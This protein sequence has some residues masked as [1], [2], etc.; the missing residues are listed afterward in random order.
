MVLF[1]NEHSEINVNI[2]INAFDTQIYEIVTRTKVTNDN[3]HQ[4]LQ[5]IEEITPQGSTNI[6]FALQQ[7]KICLTKL[8]EMYP[9]NVVSHIFMTDGEATEGSKDIHVLQNLVDENVINAFIG[10]GIEHDSVLLNVIGAVGKSAYYFIDKL[11]SSGLV[12]GVIL[13]SIIYKLV[14][15]VEITIENGFVYNFKTNEWTNTLYTGDIISEANKT[16][17]IISNDP[18]NC[19]MNIKGT[20]AN[21]RILFPSKNAGYVD[22]LTTHIYRQR[23]LQLLYQVNQ[24]SDMPTYYN[25]TPYHHRHHVNRAQN[26]NRE[27]DENTKMKTKLTDFLEELKKYMSDNNLEDDPVLK[28]LCD[29]V[30]ICFRTFGT[31]FAHMYC[32]ARQYS[33]GSQRQYTASSVVTT[34][35]YSNDDDGMLNHVLNDFNGTP[36][37]TPQ[38]TQIM[39]GICRP[40]N[41]EVVTVVHMYS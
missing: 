29:D 2:T 6:E 8:K 41:D 13:H 27:V 15:N 34:N 22:D 12:Y 30:Y 5:K 39:R 31:R 11:D 38:A 32:T 1:F 28:N 9:T 33:Q 16:Y 24:V 25:H 21:L 17:H 4:I 19:K 40:Y 10:F 3:I 26:D 35:L 20:I 14:E 36:Y 37:A 23:T 18:D 7:S